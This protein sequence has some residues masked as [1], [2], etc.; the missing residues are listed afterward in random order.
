MERYILFVFYDFET[1]GI[2]PAF[3]QP[4]QVGAILVDENF[5]EIERFELRCRLSPH[6]LPSPIALAITRV[7]PKMLTDKNLPTWFEFSQE[8]SSLIDKWSPATWIGYN[9]ISYDEEVMRHS[10]YQNLH[11]NLYKTQFDGNDRMDL[12]K[13]IYAVHA[14]I[15]NLLN[16]TFKPD[17]KLTFKLD[18]LAT[19]NGFEHHNAH[20]ALG[21]VEATIYLAKLIRNQAP[22]FWQQCLRNKDKNKVNNLLESGKPLTLVER[23]GASAPRVYTGI[24]VGRNPS[25]NNSIGFLDLNRE[26][27]LSLIES[28]DE[29]LLKA[30]SKSPQ[31]IRTIVV[32][33]FPSL[34]EIA[35]IEE[36]HLK[37]AN[38]F[39]TN[40]IFYQKI[41]RTLQAKLGDRE[42]YEH[43]EQRI[44]DAFYS[45]KDRQLL[46]QFQVS[47]WEDRLKIIG[48][49]EDARLR[50]LGN[51]IIF[52]N[53]PDL[54][55]ISKHPMVNAAIQRRWRSND[56]KAPWTN[57]VQVN[58]DLK[59]LESLNLIDASQL[60]D[61]VRYYESFN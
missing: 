42:E 44:Y 55:D 6:I 16:W 11:P 49:F 57:I 46:Q 51:R 26:D 47:S 9:N 32:N 31:E 13:I 25:Y 39:N 7:T 15:P 59:E 37:L 28:N 4:T 60:N 45:T 35:K 17:G 36:H 54:I 48:E 2:K 12:M 1:T 23:F 27:P 10:F 22:D 53:R 41:G 3:I 61:L 5:N 56:P 20:D 58:Q 43:V 8:L 50:Q 38:H 19:A 18:K 52:I 40:T 21:D 24:Y 29:T 34:F 14:L 33:K 30:V